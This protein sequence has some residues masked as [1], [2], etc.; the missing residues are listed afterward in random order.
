MGFGIKMTRNKIENCEICKMENSLGFFTIKNGI[1]VYK[2]NNCKKLFIKNE[3]VINENEKE[4]K[5][6]DE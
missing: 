1:N 5:K 3:I 4:V 2:C 6:Q